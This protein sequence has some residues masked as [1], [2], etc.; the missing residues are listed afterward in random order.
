MF[1]MSSLMLRLVEEAKDFNEI[2]EKIVKL[3]F[4]L[5]RWML[6]CV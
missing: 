4:E 1:D 5:G 6:R 3:A 2:E